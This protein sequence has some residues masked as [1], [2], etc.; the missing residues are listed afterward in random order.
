MSLQTRPVDQHERRVWRRLRQLL[1][2]S[3]GPLRT[4]QQGQTLLCIPSAITS[5]DYRREVVALLSSLERGSPL[6]REYRNG[7]SF[8]WATESLLAQ[9]NMIPPE[10]PRLPEVMRDE[11]CAR[12]EL[13]EVGW[14]S[15]TEELLS[16]I[17]Q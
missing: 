17:G 10:A 14:R 4:E 12:L 11:I 7:V 16:A 13:N 3:M 15:V 9:K 8:A 2:W 6:L 5:R 1:L